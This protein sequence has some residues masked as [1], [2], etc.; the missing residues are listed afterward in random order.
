MEEGW[1][2]R[3]GLL[4]GMG[5]GIG[6]RLIPMFTFNVSDRRKRKKQE[7]KILVMQTYTQNI[8]QLK[9][10][11]IYPNFYYFIFIEYYLKKN[12]TIFFLHR[13]CDALHD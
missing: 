7:S 10:L 6:G 9:F 4:R 2:A 8:A 1:G 5:V 13:L 3:G 12:R 11:L